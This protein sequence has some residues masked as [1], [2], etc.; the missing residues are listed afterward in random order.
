MKIIDFRLRPPFS[1]FLE[2][3]LYDENFLKGFV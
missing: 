2:G 1:N 3:W